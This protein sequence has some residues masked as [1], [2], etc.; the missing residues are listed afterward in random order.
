MFRG[1]FGKKGE[2][3]TQQ[4]VLI[5][6]LITSFAIILFF[7]FRLDLGEESESQICYNSV[8]LRGSS[9][10]PSDTTPL[11][12]SRSYVCITRD[13]SCEGQINS[14]VQRVKTESE[15]YEVL[16]ES[17][18]ECWWQFGSGEINYV[19]SDLTKNNYCSICSQL[20][21][22]D[23]LKEIEGFE[24]GVISKD[25]LYTYLSENEYRK[26]QTYSQFIFGTNDVEALKQ[27]VLNSNENSLDTGTF[28]TIEIGENQY[29]VIMSITSDISFL[30]WAGV[31][32]GTGAVLGGIG[33]FLVLSNPVGWVGGAIV[34]ASAVVVG[35]GGGTG[36]ESV[37]EYF[38][39]EIAAITVKGRGID[40]V[41]MSPTI[42]EI[43]SEKIR[44]LNCEEIITLS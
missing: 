1:I 29:Y 11:K 41:F 6:I 17:M 32:A 14:D 3:S 34:A 4:I 27:Q 15:V 40:N 22:D 13:G 16:S 39:P 36:G 9:V 33:A 20:L 26:D 37:A 2:L 12:C 10:V 21:F 25:R 24:E 7:L 44:A 19:G 28:G 42:Q 30:K 8:V 18:A 38:E 35:V 43:D 23:S 5:I 31:G